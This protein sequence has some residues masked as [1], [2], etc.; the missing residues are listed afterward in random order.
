MKQVILGTF[1]IFAVVAT[2]IVP[3]FLFGPK[4]EAYMFPVLTNIK[5]T[6]ILD[7]PTK[8]PKFDWFIIEL[9]KVRNCPPIVGSSGWYIVTDDQTIINV[10][11]INTGSASLK[12]EWRPVGHHK[13]G[14]WQVDNQARDPFY[15]QVFI[16]YHKCHPLWDTQS[17][18]TIPYGSK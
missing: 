1:A 8:D 15:K 11:A 13:L 14:A 4:F 5:V 2:I 12:M 3:L 10:G 6:R 18:I 16:S 9:D 7:D 17:I